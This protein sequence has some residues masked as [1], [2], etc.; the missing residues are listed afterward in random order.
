MRKAE[1]L[2]TPLISIVLPTYN[3]F[4]FLKQAIQSCVAQTY[5]NWELIIVDDASTDE[6]STIVAD[7]VRADERIRFIRHETNR[8]LP[9]ALNTG[10]AQAKGEL[11]TWTS[12][13]NFFR[14]NALGEMVGFLQQHPEIGLV[15]TDYSTV[16]SQGVELER[17]R[18]KEPNLL[19]YSNCVMA[20]F[21]YRRQ[22]AQKIGGYREGFFLVE[23]YDFWLRASVDFRLAALHS[24]LY[25][26]RVHSE[27][28][29]SKH[30]ERQER[31]RTRA[32]IEHVSRNIGREKKGR[33]L[34]EL[35][36][37]AWLRR[38]RTSAWG[39]FARAA[40][41]APHRVG[42]SFFRKVRAS[43]RVARPDQ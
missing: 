31:Q 4:R 38:D 21:L 24:N 20:S 32:Q 28:L 2:A 23:D 29:T 41:Y 16:D 37:L 1:M 40:I 15:Y 6:T 11:F 25:C 3:G 14:A 43:H 27:S 7:S 10:F 12:D 19:I 22:V 30:A 36:W 5:Q 42:L 17:I 8:K 9:A 34:V 26:Y 35:A 13:D 33:I 18:V 39:L